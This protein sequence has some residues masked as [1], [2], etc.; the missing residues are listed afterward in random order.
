MNALKQKAHL[1]E[2]IVENK[3]ACLFELLLED[4]V[5][6]D[7]YYDGIHNK[8]DLQTIVDDLVNHAINNVI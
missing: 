6:Y 1:I 7:I 8:V 2:S 3:T 4:R 5:F